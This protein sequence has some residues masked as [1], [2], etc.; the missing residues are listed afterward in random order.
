VIRKSFLIKVV[1]L[2]L[3]CFTLSIS[4]VMVQEAYSVEVIA[5]IQAKLDLFMQTW[6]YIKTFTTDLLTYAIWPKVMLDALLQKITSFLDQAVIQ[7]E[8][9][10]R[11]SLDDIKIDQKK[12][13][14]K[15][16]NKDPGNNKFSNS[17]MFSLNNN[18]FSESEADINYTELYELSLELYKKM[19]YGTEDTPKGIFK[20]ILPQ[21][22]DWLLD[23]LSVQKNILRQEY[24]LHRY[25]E[26]AGFKELIEVIGE[27]HAYIDKMKETL[28]TY[29]AISVEPDNGKAYPAWAQNASLS[30]SQWSTRNTLILAMINLQIYK[31]RILATICSQQGQMYHMDVLNNMERPLKRLEDTKL[32]LFN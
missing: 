23:E 14:E 2:L 28:P 19:D 4:P 6:S 9:D 13:D 32:I 18:L 17:L 7:T 30:V 5:R 20:T 27:A 12:I 15:F 8:K 26:D 21:V 31:M 16:D 11:Q 29:D 10:I 25:V 1:Y 22:N 24:L 3:I